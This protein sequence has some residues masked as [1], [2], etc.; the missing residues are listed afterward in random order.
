MLIVFPC[1]QSDSNLLGKLAEVIRHLG[2]NKGFQ[3]VVC[4]STTIVSEGRVFADAITPCFD[5][6]HFEPIELGGITGWP[7]APNKHM[8]LVAAMIATK[9][10][11]CAGWYF[12]EADN[13]PLTKEWAAKITV[14]Y[15][16]AGK[17][18]MGAVIPTRGFTFRNGQR[19]PENGNPHMVGT[20]IYP[21]LF[22]ARS[23]KLPHADKYAPWTRMPIEPWDIFV[24]DEVVPFAHNT[25][26]IQHNWQT[27]NYRVEDGKVICDDMDGITS[28]LSHKK[29]WDGVSIILHGCKD[30]SLCD[31]VLADKLPIMSATQRAAPAGVIAG[32][33]VTA[34]AAVVV[35]S[36]GPKL[37]ASFL[38]VKIQKE[39]NG[40]KM[41]AKAV[42]KNLKITIP[43]VL[44]VVAEPG[45]GLKVAGPV[46][47]IS[48]A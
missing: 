30:G 19:M 37:H 12:F 32:G 14:E 13:T 6:V 33:F 18:F 43:E 28:E 41:T 27:K 25:T 20:G 29:P 5:Q 2:P 38:A 47:W 22:G 39:L 1:S 48:M 36:S 42:A 44:S 46:K 3:A 16:S 23:V 17:P 21:S 40:G 31:I 8:R 11:T 35:G 26:L 9:F 15:Q 10:P 34:P 7:L 4:P 45:S 24:R